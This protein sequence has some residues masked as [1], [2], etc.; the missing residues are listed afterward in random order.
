[1]TRDLV[2]ESWLRAAQAVGRARSELGPPVPV[3]VPELP[4]THWLPDPYGPDPVVF[5]RVPMVRGD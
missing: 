4:A 1:V 3:A 2:T 5:G